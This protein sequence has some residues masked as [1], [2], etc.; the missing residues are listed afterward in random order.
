MKDPLSRARNYVYWLVSKQSRTK[1][2]LL[3]KLKRKEYEKDIISKVITEAEE[4]G[5]I[6]DK[7]YAFAY[8]SD[9]MN[10]YKSGRNLIKMKLMQKG[11][12]KE[13]IDKALENTFRG[14]D[15]YKQAL[16]IA[17]RRA[18][19]YKKLDEKVMARRLT[20]YIVRRGFTFDTAL[21]VTKAIIKNTNYED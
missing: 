19:T 6:N 10:F 17:K 1:K 8:A 11:V 16:D 2:E 12:D 3:D 7:K 14:V 15:E 20:S 9:R 4:N 13:L 18:R 5:L 21:R